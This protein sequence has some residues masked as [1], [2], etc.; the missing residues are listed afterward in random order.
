M[1]VETMEVETMRWSDGG[2]EAMEVETMEVETIG[3]RRWR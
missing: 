1:E 2:E 3:W